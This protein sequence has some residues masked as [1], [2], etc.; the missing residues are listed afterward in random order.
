MY[1]NDKFKELSNLICLS[2]LVR[3]KEKK[4]ERENDCAL[5]SGI[6]GLL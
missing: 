5:N 1:H 2:V 6:K 3:A 4:I